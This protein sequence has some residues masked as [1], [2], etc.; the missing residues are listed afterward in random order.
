MVDMLLVWRIIGTRPGDCRDCCKLMTCMTMHASSIEQYNDTQ[1]A[2]TEHT[3]N[4]TTAE[5]LPDCYIHYLR[6]K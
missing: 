5:M 4:T 3:I 1:H 6:L 2:M